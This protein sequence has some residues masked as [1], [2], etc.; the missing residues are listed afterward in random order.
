MSQCESKVIVEFD[1]P[2]ERRKRSVGKVVDMTTDF[3]MIIYT[4]RYS[5]FSNFNNIAMSSALVSEYSIPIDQFDSRRI[6]LR[7]EIVR[8][9]SNL[10]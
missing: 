2:I 4:C 6:F 10:Q 7:L 9:L 1:R 5:F 3:L 8:R